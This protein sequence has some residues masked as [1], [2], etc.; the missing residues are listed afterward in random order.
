MIDS[1]FDRIKTPITIHAQAVTI[2]AIEA[3]IFNNVIWPD[4]ARLPSAEKPVLRYESLQPGEI[5]QLA[6]LSFEM[7]P[8]NHVVPAVGYCLT[9]PNGVIAF[10]GDTST[11]D[12]F[13]EALNRQQR[14]DVLIVES[15]F[16][17]EDH[18]LSQQAGHYCPRT[19]AADLVK[20]KHQ[21]E[22][23]LSHH[24]PGSEKIIFDECKQA[25]TDRN[26]ESLRG[27]QRFQL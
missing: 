23:Y 5:C 2:K 17:N 6:D 14:L 10:S 11:N 21:P 13:W 3:H 7:I 27:G 4:F 16:T 20:L 12:T 8:V 19:L 9:A 26:I 15:A 18:P 22:I 1:I 24:K 25:I